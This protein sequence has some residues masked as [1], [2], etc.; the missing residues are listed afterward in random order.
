MIS[1]RAQKVT[2]HLGYFW[3]KICS[4]DLSKMAQCVHTGVFVVA[5]VGVGVGRGGRDGAF[6]AVVMV[7]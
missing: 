3:K 5:V 2:V 6:V 7:F 1:K 4:Q